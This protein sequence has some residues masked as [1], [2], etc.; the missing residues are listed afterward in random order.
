MPLLVNAGNN[1]FKIEHYWDTTFV[2]WELI[3]EPLPLFCNHL[4]VPS[5]FGQGMQTDL[6]CL[7][8]KAREPCNSYCWDFG[9]ESTGC[10]GL[11]SSPCDVCVARHCLGKRT[12]SVWRM[13][14]L[15]VTRSWNVHCK[16]ISVSD[17]GLQFPQVTSKLC[18]SLPVPLFISQA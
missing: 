9:N 12:G 8:S 17:K 11:R 16:T 6:L 18:H 7:L 3:K 15:S 1:V 2:P 5:P 4:F 14:W 10:C 13:P